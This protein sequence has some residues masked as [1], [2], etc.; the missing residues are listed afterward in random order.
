MSILQASPPHPSLRRSSRRWVELLT[1]VAENQQGSRKNEY[2]PKHRPEDFYVPK[3]H[4]VRDFARQLAEAAAKNVAFVFTCSFPDICQKP[5]LENFW[6]FDLG[7][8]KASCSYLLA[9]SPSGLSCTA[10]SFT[11]LAIR[12][13]RFMAR[14]P[15][16]PLV[17]RYVGSEPKPGT[18]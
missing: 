1:T 6:K 16:L 13:R 5:M 8:N 3:C 2:V 17:G 9:K 18:K 14:S 12:V 10:P 15:T 11:W 7:T 4:E